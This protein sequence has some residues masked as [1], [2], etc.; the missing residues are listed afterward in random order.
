[1]GRVSC[2]QQ[3]SVSFSQIFRLSGVDLFGLHEG[4][5][6]NDFGK[7]AQL[8]NA[9]TTSEDDVIVDAD[10]DDGDDDALSSARQ[11][12]ASTL[13]VDECN[14]DSGVAAFSGAKLGRLL[15][16]KIVDA[17][18]LADVGSVATPEDEIR[19]LRVP[20]GRIDNEET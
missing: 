11:I 1:M 10:D 14:N 3:I 9:I 5:T 8:K 4:L 2:C 12:T 18:D 20:K 13:F 16:G 15:N 17:A 19:F 6:A 7:L